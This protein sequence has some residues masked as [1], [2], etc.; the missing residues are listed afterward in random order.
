MRKIKNMFVPWHVLPLNIQMLLKSI[1][2][3][4]DKISDA[5]DWWIEGIGWWEEH[6]HVA[7][8]RTD[9]LDDDDIGIITEM[10]NARGDPKA[11]D[12]VG[13]RPPGRPIETSE[14][15]TCGLKRFGERCNHIRKIS[16]L[17]LIYS[18][19]AD[20][21]IEIV[22]SVDVRFIFTDVCIKGLCR[23]Y[24][25]AAEKKCTINKG[26]VTGKMKP[27]AWNE[28]PEDCVKI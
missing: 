1:H 7:R 11:G 2:P 16:C 9:K 8:L 18:P 14:Y 21:R 3:G 23:H 15:K 25:P 12:V 6:H 10:R 20:I 5:G 22:P 26:T 28:Y 27:C 13:C 19:T 4:F 17:E 24:N